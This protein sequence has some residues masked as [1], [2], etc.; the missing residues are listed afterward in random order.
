VKPS[1]SVK[2]GPKLSDLRLGYPG[3]VA[4]AGDTL[5]AEQGAH[6]IHLSS[7]ITMFFEEAEQI[8]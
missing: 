8:V 6:G 5:F 1:A 7:L 3:R 4:A 2:F